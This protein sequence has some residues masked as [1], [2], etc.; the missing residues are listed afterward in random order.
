[1]KQRTK[2]LAAWGLIL[3]V[4]LIGAAGCERP[5]PDQP[6]PTLEIIISPQA[7][8]ATEEHQA[9]TVSVLSSPTPGTPPPTFGW[10]VPSFTPT[11]EAPA[12]P[13]ATP[14]SQV[15]QPPSATPTTDAASPTMPP[16]GVDITHTVAW[17]DT[18]FSLAQRYGVTVD[19]I[20]QANGLPNENFIRI[21]QILKIPQG[22]Q[23]TP[24][25]TTST[26]T[27]VYTV[28][29]GDTLYR[30]ASIYGTTANAIAQQNGIVNPTL[31]QI[32]Q[33]LT[34]PTSGTGSGVPSATGGVYVVQPGDT[35][36][37]IAARYGTTTWD[38]AYANNLP[39]ANFIRAGQ[40]LVIPG[41]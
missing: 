39:N 36:S 17:G 32:G 38:I 35:L 16:T 6:T 40:T 26:G 9:T 2:H 7:P 41:Q 5:V 28:Q 19:A 1:M 34:I 10:V 30:I 24:G 14:L 31:L 20:V 23:Q 33:Q 15:V 3:M 13:T 12:A 18:L 37:S 25:G 21:G 29:P 11:P 22:V 4:V 8:P 27:V